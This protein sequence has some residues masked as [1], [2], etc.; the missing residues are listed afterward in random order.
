MKIKF[1]NNSS[2]VLLIK[3]FRNADSSVRVALAQN[4]IISAA[5]ADFELI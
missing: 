1:S 2:I 3:Y 5:N 4:L